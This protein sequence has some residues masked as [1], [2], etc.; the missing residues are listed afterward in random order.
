[1]TSSTVSAL[2]QQ[3]EAERILNA[4]RR[5]KASLV[6]PSI[7]LFGR[8]L[9]SLIFILS[10]PGHFSTQTIAYAAARREFLWRQSQCHSPALSRC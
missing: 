5:E 2:P 3:S 10:A 6:H 7:V 8:L 4:T 1:M 9:F